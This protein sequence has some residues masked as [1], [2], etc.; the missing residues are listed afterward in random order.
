MH[1]VT[2]VGNLTDDPIL[3]VSNTRNANGYKTKRATFC[4]AVN[5]GEKDTDSEK[6]YFL[7]TTAFGTL[8]ENVANSLAKG[9]RVIIT[10]RFNQYDKEVEIDG[11]AKNLK[12]TSFNAS[13]VGPDLRWANATPKKVVVERDDEDDNDEEEETEQESEEKPKAKTKAAPKTK[14]KA[15]A[16]SAPA[17]DDDDF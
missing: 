2:F 4:V 3:R 12:M 17:D 8:G 13:A 7:N 1:N 11:E 9:Q 6:T 10:G 15:P 5:E 14:P 16:K